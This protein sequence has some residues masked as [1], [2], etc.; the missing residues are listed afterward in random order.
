MM[1]PYHPV[2]GWDV[3]RGFWDAEEPCADEES[4]WEMVEQRLEMQSCD[5][6]Q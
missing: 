1:P 2:E 5:G 4:F 6:E 3:P